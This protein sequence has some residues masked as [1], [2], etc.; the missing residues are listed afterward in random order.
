MTN[1]FNHRLDTLLREAA[2]AGD[3]DA[4]RAWRMRHGLPPE[5]VPM[6]RLTLADRPDQTA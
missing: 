5:P 6:R 2:K 1:D 4:K 3:L